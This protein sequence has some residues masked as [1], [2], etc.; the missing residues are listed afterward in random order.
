MTGRAVRR[1][2]SCVLVATVAALLAGC[3]SKPT[4]QTA[5]EATCRREA[6]NDPQVRTLMTKAIPGGNHIFDFSFSDP[7]TEA[8][9]AYRQAFQACLVR[10]GLASGGVEPI[11]QYPYSP[12]AF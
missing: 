6:Y 11:K 1:G 7:Q 10:L 5:G 3:A 12:L 8:N 4:P 2:V 9:Y